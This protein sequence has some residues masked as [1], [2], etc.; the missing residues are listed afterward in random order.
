MLMLLDAVA[1]GNAALT[2]FEFE[3]EFGLF[4]WCPGH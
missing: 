2:E 1:I 4:R 3:F